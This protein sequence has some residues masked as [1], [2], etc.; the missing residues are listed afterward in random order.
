MNSD[1]RI[2]MVINADKYL[3]MFLN[4]SSLTLFHQSQRS[5]FIFIFNTV[6]NTLFVITF[7]FSLF[8]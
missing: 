1:K 6:L 8:K 7:H 4:K 2:V 3:F 5:Y